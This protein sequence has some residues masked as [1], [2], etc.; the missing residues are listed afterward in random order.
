MWPS[1]ESTE[2]TR[3]WTVSP[4]VLGGCLMFIDS[5]LG[6]VAVL[7]IGLDGLLNIGLDISLV[8]G[9]PAYALDWRTGRRVIV[10]LPAL[11][12][13]RWLV[14]SQIGPAPYHLGP[15]WRGS[16][17]LFVASVLLQLSKLKNQPLARRVGRSAG[18]TTRF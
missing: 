2:S 12:L 5:L 14:G 9:L 8:A 17:L 11:Y 6:A 16:L 13:F 10:F 7:G 18:K 3:R 4:A 15:P 1:S